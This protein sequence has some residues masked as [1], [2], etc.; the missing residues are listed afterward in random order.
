MKKYRLGLLILLLAA[1]LSA[2]SHV[3]TVFV[4]DSCN[5]SLDGITGLVR[6]ED[7]DKALQEANLLSESFGKQS[8]TMA[9]YTSH[10]KLDEVRI[11]L[12]RLESYLESQ[13]VNDSLAEIRA[14]RAKLAILEEEEQLRLSNVL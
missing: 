6:Q 2:V 3:Y 9:F 7:F 13:S 8:N 10:G 5:R 11:C 14:I 1:A 4:T 12:N